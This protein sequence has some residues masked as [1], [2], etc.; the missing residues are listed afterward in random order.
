LKYH[1]IFLE[2]FP[3]VRHLVNNGAIHMITLEWR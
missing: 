1:E 2:F 3:L